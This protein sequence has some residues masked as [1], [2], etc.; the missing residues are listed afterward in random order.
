MPTEGHS[1]EPAAQDKATMDHSMDKFARELASGNLSRRRLL[2][3]MGT[4]L[5]GATLASIPGV[6]WAARPPGRGPAGKNG[7]PQA[8]Q[9]RCRGACV[10]LSSDPNNCGACGHVCPG[11]HLCVNGTC[12]ECPQ[13][14]QTL[15]G[16]TCTD[17]SWDSNNCGACGNV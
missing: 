11:G 16:G 1:R 3:W 13:S 4:A 9:V 10:F 2:K 14:Y 7:C 15:C 6:A 12:Q 8:G 5:V 17:V